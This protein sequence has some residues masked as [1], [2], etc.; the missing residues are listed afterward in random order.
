MPQDGSASEELLDLAYSLLK[1]IPTNIF[2]GVVRWG[3]D[4]ILAEV[5]GK[6][7]TSQE[8]LA[9]QEILEGLKDLQTAVS[10]LEKEVDGNALDALLE[11]YSKLGSYKLP[12]ELYRALL[13]VDKD[14]TLTEAEKKQ[15]RL[16]ILTDSIGAGGEN[17]GCVDTHFD[18]YVNALADAM[19]NT[20][21]V[22]LKGQQKNLMLFQVHYEYL[23]RKYHWENQAVDEWVGF[24]TQALGLLVETLAIER[25]SLYAR[26]ERIDLYNGEHPDSPI[27]KCVVL[28]ALDDLQGNKERQITGTIE[29]VM[30]LYI[31]E[32]GKDPDW[33]PKPHAE[34][35]RY[36]WTPGHERLFYAEVNTQHVP[37]EPRQDQGWH[38]AYYGAGGE[39]Q[40]I[41][42]G[43]TDPDQ[44]SIVWAFW[45]PFFRPR[46]TR[47]LTDSELEMIFTDYNSEAEI[48][49][50]FYEIFMDEDEGDFQGLVGDKDLEWKMVFDPDSHHLEMHWPF[51]TDYCTVEGYFFD[52]KKSSSMPKAEKMKIARYHPR[53]NREIDDTF[54][55]G[56]RLKQDAGAEPGIGDV[57]LDIHS[58]ENPAGW[59]PL[60]GDLCIPLDAEVF[61]RI[62]RVEADGAVLPE[63]SYSTRDHLVMLREDYLSSLEEGVHTFTAFADGGSVS[64]TICLGAPVEL[65]LPDDLQELGDEALK[66]IGTRS[67]RI[68]DSCTHIGAG[69]FAD[70]TDLTWIYIPDSVKQIETGAFDNCPNLVLICSEDSAAADYAKAND[71]PYRQSKT[72]QQGDPTAQGT[73]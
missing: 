61:G 47:L 58:E 66:S 70:C 24:Q 39:L 16:S 27:S 44:T 6:S 30:K 62:L 5:F 28:A 50:S 37:K 10:N 38:D 41:T 71:I 51:N 25:L 9:L 34:D 36:Y 64:R 42:N 11:A 14:D 65:A 69:A 55:I 12:G 52:A 2:G 21:Y 22:M 63:S 3:T 13:A 53:Y 15:Q 1:A 56:I 48:K 54:F 59:I 67:V 35:E 4:A 18:N 17:I 20:H 49:K 23:R 57:H 8:E 73:P 19:L 32:G 43:S 46:P 26:L 33:L 72:N 40:G 7:F 29:K 68:N 31:P 60:D 45:K